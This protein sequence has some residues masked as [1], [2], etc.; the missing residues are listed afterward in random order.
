MAIFSAH[1]GRRTDRIACAA[2][3]EVNTGK[4]IVLTPN[5]GKC[6]QAPVAE[7]PPNVRAGGRPAC[8]RPAALVASLAVLAM[9][10][11]HH[12]AAGWDGGAADAAVVAAA[13]WAG[14]LL[15]GYLAT[16]V[17]TVALAGAGGRLRRTARVVAAPLPPGLHR[18]LRLALGVGVATAVVT[19]TAA[20]AT[21]DGPGR[22]RP[23]VSSLDWPGVGNPPI[24]GRRPRWWSGP[25]TRCGHRGPVPGTDRHRG[26]RR[27]RLAAL[28]GGQPCGDRRRPRPDP[29]RPAAGAA[30]SRPEET[31]MTP[32]PTAPRLRLLPPPASDPPYDDEALDRAP[33]VRGSL[34]LA[35]PPDADGG[36]P[37]RLVP[38]AVPRP[39]RRR[40]AAAG[41]AGLEPADR[42]GGRRGARRRARSGAA[43]RLRV[44]GGAPSAR[45]G[46]RPV[47]RS[48][49]LDAPAA[50]PHLRASVPATPAASRR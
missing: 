41:P 20:P 15:A 39:P 37:L 49:R 31:T 34:A 6:R 14:W 45:A 16:V 13:A 33:V 8:R 35:F 27:A 29:S 47:A 25:A 30:G 32:A 17:A 10:A 21:A 43:Q 38:P 42:R 18:R 4:R 9:L 2:L 5:A 48:G 22:P 23:H 12:P 1:R 50:A 26:S 28:V 46:S 19:A 7:P 3:T 40:R 44:A 36:M 24:A 11:Q